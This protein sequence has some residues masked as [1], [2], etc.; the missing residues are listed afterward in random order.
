M[1]ASTSKQHLTDAAYNRRSFLKSSVI[2]TSALALGS[3]TILRARNLNEKLNLA[4]IGTGG[5]GG[6][7]MRSVESQN[8][9]ALCD[10]NE[11]NLNF[12][13]SR[14]SRAR[15]TTDFRKLYDHAGEF[16][17]VVVSTCEHP[18]AC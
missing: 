12:G 7:N 10:V 11:N 6:A 5:R 3:P 8:I 2:A 9:V 4:I 17:A 1:T 14:H 15:H 16:D 13:K 18:H